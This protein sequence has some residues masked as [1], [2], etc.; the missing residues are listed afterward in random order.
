MYL[1]L[2]LTFCLIS[3]CN[4]SKT[5]NYKTIGS[6]DVV[7]KSMEKYVSA[8]AKIQVLAEGFS[9]SEGPVWV[10]KLNGLL[11]TDV[12]ENKAYLWTEGKG[13]SLFL[14]PSGSTGYAANSAEEGANGLALD[15]EGNLILCQHGDRR[16]AR[17]KNWSFEVPE[18]E[19][20][21]NM[22]EGNILNSPNDLAISKN[23]TIYF[24]DPPYG[25]D[26]QDDDPLKKLSFNGVYKLSSDKKPQLLSKNLNRPNGIALSIDEKILYVSNSDPDNAIIKSYEITPYGIVNEKVFFDGNHLTKNNEGLFDGLKIHSSGTIFAT[27]PGGVLIIDSKGNHLGTIKPN[28]RTANCAFDKNQNYLYMTSH[29]KLTRV[30]INTQ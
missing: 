20:I 23:G 14:Y 18:Y 10:P 13:L 27:G 11:F 26:K 6:I 1:K 12:P 3:A 25:L 17:L 29:S 24:T 5:F 21:I 8:G 7:Q 15:K 2:F 30:K 9:W 28:N 22:F 19:T 4:E 16:I